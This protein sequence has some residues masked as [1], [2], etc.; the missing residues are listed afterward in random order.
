MIEAH[1]TDREPGPGEVLRQGEQADGLSGPPGGRLAGASTEPRA[2]RLSRW[3]LVVLGGIVAAHFVYSMGQFSPAIEGPDANGYWAQGTRIATT[4][5]AWF[6]PESDLQ[7]IDIHWINNGTG[8]YYS[9]Y[10]PG[11][12]ILVAPLFRL[13]G[14]RASLLLD[15]I[16][17]SLTLVG[18]FF[19]LRYWTR[20]RWALVG[21]LVLALNPVLNRQVTWAFAHISV[22]FFLVWGIHLLLRWSRD[23]RWWQLFAAAALLGCIPTIRYP[24]VI[25]GLGIGVFI[26]WR[27]IEE[28]RPW[29]QLLAAAGGIAL[30]LLPLAFYLH[31]IYGGIFRT[32][33]GFTE[34]H[35]VFGWGYLVEHFLDYLGGMHALGLGPFFALGLM[36][37]AVMCWSRASRRTGVL[38]V[39]LA[40]P[41]LLLIMAYSGMWPPRPFEVTLMDMDTRT[42]LP[43]F[44]FYIAAA[45]WLLDRLTERLGGTAQA[46]AIG[47]IVLFQCAW[48]A[49][50]QG[51]RGDRELYTKQV[52]V[53]VTDTLERIV[54]D[55]DVVVARPL[56]LQHLDYV[57][58][59]RLGEIQKLR[60]ISSTP[61]PPCLGRYGSPH[62]E[63]D[64]R[65]RRRQK[66]GNLSRQEQELGMA[67]ELREWADGRGVFFVGSEEN[68]ID[69]GRAWFSEHTVE[70]VARV[71]LP[72]NLVQKPMELG[73]ERHPLD[74]LYRAIDTDEIVIARWLDP[75]SSSRA[76]RS[77]T[78]QE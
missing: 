7:Y 15:P 20:D 3:S 12:A 63:A 45:I 71:P 40:L 22:L 14:H 4:G 69:M 8:R 49:S 46:C 73:Q 58:R 72:E 11:H 67:E 50:V 41:M 38:L 24:D 32:G 21:V 44:V 47:G 75:P 51:T 74:A 5:H 35:V 31:H 34:E 36:G 42:L 48:G 2:G 9:S 17:V 18:F 1:M 68:L 39:L 55:G 29:S 70:V 76:R 78:R 64:T 62:H 57:G 53:R 77:S 19:L 37:M 60:P 52:L 6:S 13:F 66:Y 54:P 61:L 56:F 27:C 65:Q 30:P 43:S 33:Y 25:F 23:G 10:P 16:L 26:I 59:W 28:K